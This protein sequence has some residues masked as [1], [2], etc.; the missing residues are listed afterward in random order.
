MS[1]SLGEYTTSYTLDGVPY[2]TIEVGSIPAGYSEVDVMVVDNGT[3]VPCKMVA[4]H[5]AMA[6]TAREPGGVVN[7]IAPAPQWFML[8]K[9][10]A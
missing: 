2:F 9:K 4:G 10:T 3:E 5:V 7:T 8:E 6:A 1:I